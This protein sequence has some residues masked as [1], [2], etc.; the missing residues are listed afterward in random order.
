MQQ[1]MGGLPFTLASGRVVRT[2]IVYIRVSTA[3][4]DMKSPE[5]QLNICQF[6]AAS[7]NIQI[8]DVVP[9]L[10]L[11][12][13]DFAKRKIGDIIERV[14]ANEA[15]A[16]IVWEYSRFG[17]TLVGSLYY[18]KQLEAA[19]G[20]LLS[21]TQDIDATTPA[22]RY[23]R[24]QFLR[25]AE[26]Q[27]DQ[28]TDGWKS[29]HKRRIANGLPHGGQERF[30]YR[31]CRGCFRPEENSRS[32]ACKEKCG[33]LLVPDYL[34][35]D[36]EERTLRS[37][38][39]DRGFD[40]FVHGA[41]M[42][43]VAKDAW[44][45]G[46]VS[47]RGNRMDESAWRAVMDSG[48]SAGLLR[49]RSD[50]TTR[51]TST[52]PDVYDIWGDGAHDAI[53]SQEVWDAYVE[54][55]IRQANEHQRQST[56]KFAYSG[57]VRCGDLKHDGTPCKHSMKIIGQTRKGKE[58]IR[59][60]TCTRDELHARGSFLS[61]ALHRIEKVVLDWITQMSKGGEHLAQISME[62]A[63]KAEQSA[64]EIPNVQKE[65][66]T[67]ER[68]KARINE[69]WEAGLTEL[70]EAKAKMAAVKVEIA[71]TKAKLRR[72]ETE[73]ATNRIPEKE[74]FQGLLAVWE[75]ATPTEKRRALSQ[76]IDHVRI[77]PPKK[78]ATQGS[79]A[80]II[81]LWADDSERILNQPFRKKDAAAAE[82]AA[83]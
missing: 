82:A 28:I 78:S 21:A 27:L 67:L 45:K 16:I 1:T 15:D 77:T 14:R 8:V 40:M 60:Y 47:L 58:T 30:G 23:M 12:G 22:G 69:G 20:E 50:K 54:R 11:S 24:D 49:G 68:K 56:P 63:A 43:Q 36:E 42:Y 83:A 70:D 64:S 29:T 72:L 79:D 81:P 41:S 4:E 74:V 55:R 26:Y 51:P 32:Y 38:Q 9:D 62:R 37:V 48:F 17:R 65:L 34:A 35:D 66:A 13:A 59:Y 25:L 44:Q 39:L 53:I 76:V 2:A 46:V 61:M 10:D 19:G 18:I 3:R 7:K 33:G 73:A 52:R 5:Q 6:Y 80:T 71:D 31:R 75:R 57:L